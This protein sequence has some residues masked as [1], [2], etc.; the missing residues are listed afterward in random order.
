LLGDLDEGE[1]VGPGDIKELNRA[2]DLSLHASMED[3]APGQQ[4]AFSLDASEGENGSEVSERKSQCLPEVGAA[5]QSSPVENRV[6]L[7]ALYAR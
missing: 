3:A 6:V 7:R 5:L 1:G 2:T 4:T